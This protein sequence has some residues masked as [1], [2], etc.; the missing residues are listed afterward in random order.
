[1]KLT[2]TVNVDFRIELKGYSNSLLSGCLEHLSHIDILN[3]NA[4]TR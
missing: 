1:M 4:N 2:L 3:R